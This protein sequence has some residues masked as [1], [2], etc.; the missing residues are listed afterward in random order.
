MVINVLNRIVHM[1]SL[2]EKFLMKLAVWEIFHNMSSK[3]QQ[4]KLTL[5]TFMLQKLSIVHL[6]F[7]TNTFANGTICGITI[8]EKVLRICQW[9][10][11]RIFLPHK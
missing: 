1:T 8:L 2:W 10:E 4:K 6:L 5:P 7:M 11:N 9:F 3:M